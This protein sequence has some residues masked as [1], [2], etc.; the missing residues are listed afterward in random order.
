V[1]AT[2]AA[3]WPGEYTSRMF[4]GVTA[5]ALA[6]HETA[7]TED[8]ATFDYNNEALAAKI[9]QNVKNVNFLGAQVRSLEGYYTY[10]RLTHKHDFGFQPVIHLIPAPTSFKPSDVA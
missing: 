3:G 7:K 2:Q 6:L 10:T 9:L 4:D 5:M 1:W 8:L